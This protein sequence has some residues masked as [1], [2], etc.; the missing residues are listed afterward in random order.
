MITEIITV[1]NPY[2]KHDEY[3]ITF[4]ILVRITLSDILMRSYHKNRVF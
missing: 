1:R 2:F 4:S 3:C